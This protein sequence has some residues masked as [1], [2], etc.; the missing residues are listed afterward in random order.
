MTKRLVRLAVVS[1]AVVA[2]V[3]PATSAHAYL[4]CHDMSTFEVCTP[5]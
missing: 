3:M 2:V 1:A 5:I 4:Y